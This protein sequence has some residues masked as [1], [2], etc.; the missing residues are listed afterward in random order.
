MTAEDRLENEHIEEKQQ[1]KQSLTGMEL[2]IS[3]MVQICRYQQHR[4]CCERH[5]DLPARKLE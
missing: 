4:T 5:V 2:D 1:Q 3:S